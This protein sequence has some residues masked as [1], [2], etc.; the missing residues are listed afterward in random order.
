MHLDAG[1]GKVDKF[2]IYNLAKPEAEPEKLQGSDP[3]RFA[4]WHQDDKLILSTYVDKP[5]IRC[6]P[7]YMHLT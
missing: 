6:L 5:H 7:P 1:Y 2:K 3:V 4:T